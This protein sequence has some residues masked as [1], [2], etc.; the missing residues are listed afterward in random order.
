MK[1]AVPKETAPY[2][3][4]VA[5][6][7]E[8]VARL[9]KSGLE[10]QVEELAGVGASYPD[11][12]YQAAGA[13]IIPD[14]KTLFSTADI[15]I[16]VQKP[17]PEELELLREGSVLIGILQ[18]LLNPDLV[19]RLAQ[20]KITAFAMDMIPRITRAQPMDVLSSQSTVAGYK[21]V[22]LAA[23]Y[24]PKFFPM[25][26]TAAGT[27]T[28]AKVFIIGAGVAGLQAI[29][30]RP[31]IGGSRPGVRRPPRR[32]ARSG[33]LGRQVRGIRFR[34]SRGQ[35]RLRQGALRGTQTERARAH[36]PVRQRR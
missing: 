32:Q 4:R 7:P 23:Q 14:R 34:R 36:R 9:V 10:V 5:L 22:L 12:Q 1:I 33:E 19:Q 17:S 6:V 26:S 16:K 11:A 25:L 21:A 29:A 35:I 18:P 20:K 30:H 27:I 13:T 24:L 31:T 28:P 15:L 3:R 2:E 8:T